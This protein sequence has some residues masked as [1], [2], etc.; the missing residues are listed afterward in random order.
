MSLYGEDNCNETF[1]ISGMSKL[2]YITNTSLDGYVEDETGAFDW[3]NPDQV[4]AFVTELLRPVGTYLY[5]R[6]LYETIAYFEAPV[7]GSSPE[8]LDFAR[9]WQKAEKIVF[10]RTLTGATTRN[11]RVERDFDVEAIRKLKRESEHDINI[12]GAELAGL[13]LEA[14]LIDECHLFLNPVIVGGGK[15]AFRAGLRRNLE[16]LETRRFGTG[17][18]HLRYRIRGLFRP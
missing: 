2:I 1:H 4:H 5:G 15:P 11:T 14:D 8:H 9:V 18:I 10:S 16:L 13:A 7:E 3:V 6:R 12:G 17:V